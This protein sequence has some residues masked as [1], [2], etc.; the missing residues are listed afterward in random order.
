[1]K[2]IKIFIAVVMLFKTFFAISQTITGFVFEVNENKQKVPVPGVNVYWLGT[3]TA[4]VS[5]AEGKF[6]ISKEKVKDLR[7]IFQMLSYK[8]DTITLKRKRLKLSMK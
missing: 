2:T 8:T 6:N 1:M 5:D 3:T 7:L 4:I